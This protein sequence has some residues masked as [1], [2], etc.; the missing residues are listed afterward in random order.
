VERSDGLP[1]SASCTAPASVS[2]VW[3]SC[4]TAAFVASSSVVL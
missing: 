1:S 2:S 4:S 3:R